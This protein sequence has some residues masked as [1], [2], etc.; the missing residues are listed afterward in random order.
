MAETDA[1]TDPQADDRI[2]QLET[3]DRLAQSFGRSLDTALTRGAASGRSL[4][5]VLGTIGARLAGVAAR[6]AAG[7]IQSG[8]TGLV[9]AML[10]SGAETGFARGGVFRGGRVQPFAAGG[11]VA[12]P[13]YFP[14]A[15]GAGLMGEAGPEAILPLGR[16]PDGRLGVA[17]GG[18]PT[19]PVSVTV[20]IATPDP[21]A[22]RRS[23]AQVTASLARAVARGQRAT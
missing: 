8:L 10:G 15:G 9:G 5:G 20:N 1:Q 13:T 7:P 18:A 11:V 22:F 4:D 23:E 21:G 17:A 19:R 3:L 16:G 12:A 6:A 2:R 14:M